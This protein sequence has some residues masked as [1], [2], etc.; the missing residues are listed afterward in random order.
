MFEIPREKLDTKVKNKIFM[1]LI[2]FSDLP[3]KFSNLENQEIDKIN[4][5]SYEPI[6]DYP[7]STRD[8]SFVLSDQTKIKKLEDIILNFKSENLKSAFVFDFYNN[9]KTNQIKI[10][11]RLIFNSKK[12]T[13]TVDDVDYEIDHVVSSCVAIGGVEIPGYSK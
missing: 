7:S 8:L 6:S 1:T 4:F 13:L 12:K 3:D 9:E 11:F 2:K 10:G 5:N